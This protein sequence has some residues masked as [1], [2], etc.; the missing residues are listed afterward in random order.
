[1]KSTLNFVAGE[2]DDKESTPHGEDMALDL[3]LVASHSIA[4]LCLLFAMLKR[5]QMVYSM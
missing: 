2:E 3:K 4:S 1:M 5:A